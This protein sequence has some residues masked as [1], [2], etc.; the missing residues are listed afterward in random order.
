[1][2][3]EFRGAGVDEVGIAIATGNLLVRISPDYFS[4][5]EV[6]LLNGEYAKSDALFSRTPTGHANLL[7]SELVYLVLLC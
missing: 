4:S 5:T 3:L 1:M 2:G 6:D 7:H